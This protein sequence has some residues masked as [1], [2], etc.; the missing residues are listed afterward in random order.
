MSHRN[1]N[2][3]FTIDELLTFSKKENYPCITSNLEQILNDYKTNQIDSLSF[4]IS[5]KFYTDLLFSKR[6]FDCQT[7]I[8]EQQMSGTNDNSLI[9]QCFLNKCSR[10]PKPYKK[11]IDRLKPIRKPIKFNN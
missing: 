10:F 5:I 8:K 7:R 2:K 9:I 4:K 1:K 3:V 6:F 11:S